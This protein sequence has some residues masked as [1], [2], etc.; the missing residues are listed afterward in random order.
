M[1]LRGPGANAFPWGESHSPG[2]HTCSPRC[3]CWSQAGALCSAP[4]R[5]APARRGSHS[6]IFQAAY[7]SFCT[8]SRSARAAVRPQPIPPCSVAL[9]SWGLSPGSQQQGKGKVV[10][11]L[12]FKCS[13]G[14]RNS[15]PEPSRFVCKFPPKEG[16]F[17][18]EETLP[19]NPQREQSGRRL[20][21]A[22]C[23]CGA[24][25]GRMISWRMV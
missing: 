6:P 7:G 4:V 3:T 25:T 15:S 8:G 21:A 2:L 9:S 18:N 13:T 17:L 22:R 5:A 24:G 14:R 20:G 19:P 23:L 12:L 11:L 10:A 1:L 16:N